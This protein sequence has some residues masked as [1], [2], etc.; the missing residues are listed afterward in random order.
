MKAKAL[1]DASGEAEGGDENSSSGNKID[2]DNG[3]NSYKSWRV[4]R[5]KNCVNFG[6]YSDKNNVNSKNH[7]TISTQDSVTTSHV[8]PTHY[9]D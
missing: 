6:K 8:L 4:S 2:E 1:E 7:S 9:G 3:C 5:I